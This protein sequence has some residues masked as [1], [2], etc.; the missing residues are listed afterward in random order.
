MAE[1][2]VDQIAQIGEKVERLLQELDRLRTKNRNLTEQ[3]KT[4]EGRLG[5]SQ[6]RVE[7][8]A[9]QSRVQADVHQKL[10]DLI[11]RL[12]AAETELV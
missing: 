11:G 8:A 3:I 10:E 2:R 9:R 6:P 4:L 7:K 1:K 5:K 12:E